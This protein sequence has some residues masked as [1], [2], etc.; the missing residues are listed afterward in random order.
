ML[1]PIYSFSLLHPKIGI[2]SFQKATFIF[3]KEFQALEHLS[4]SP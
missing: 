1:N 3:V 4:F 2:K